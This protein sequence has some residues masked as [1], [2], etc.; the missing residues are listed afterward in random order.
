[1]L[2]YNSNGKV[3][4]FEDLLDPTDTWE[5]GSIIG[6][7]TYGAVFRGFNK[8][9][10]EEVAIKVLDSAHEMI[11][12][13][14]EEYQIL[15]DFSEHPNMPKFYGMY[16]KHASEFDSQVWLVM[17]MCSGGSVTALTRSQL[18]EEEYLQELL[19]AH[20]LK[21]TLTVLKYLHEHNIIHRDVKGHNIL[22]T[23]AGIIKMIDFGVSGHLDSP[24]GRRK[25]HVGTPYWMAPEVIACEQQL[26]YSYDV[27]CDIWSLG[28]TA[29]ELAEGKPPHSDV[30][31]R[32]ALF[33][34]PR[35]P[36]PTLSKGVL[37]SPEFH[38][39]IAKCL[40][41]DF[42]QRS[43]T[44]DLLSHPFIQKVPTDT[45][46]LRK[47]LVELISKMEQRVEPPHVTTKHGQFKSGRKNHKESS[48]TVDD[49]A[50][51]ETLDEDVIIK[52]LSSRYSDE[53][54]YTY[55]GDILLAVNP[56]TPLT[57]YSEELAQRYMHAAKADNPPHI[58][59]VA[60]QAYQS[61][62][63]N[64]HNQCIVIS[65]ESGAG[66]TESAN[67]LV[68]QLTL[69][70]KA[71]NRKLEDR[72]LQVNPLMEAFGN[73]K[74][75]I[76]D[77]S[78]RFGKYLE[79]FFT[80]STGTV[81]GA[82][83]TEYLLEKSRVINQAIGEQ[84]FHIFYYIHDGLVSHDNESE[85]HL[86][87]GKVYRYIY[88]YTSQQQD[89]AAFS[90]NRVRFKA[91]EYCF[92]II[93]FQPD[94]VQSVYRILVAILHTGNIDF[95]ETENTHGGESCTVANNDIVEIVARMLGLDIKDLLECLTTTGMV[96]KGE[97]IVRANSVQEAVIARDAMAKALYGRLFS[98]IVNRIS[99]LLKPTS[100][101][102]ND[103][104]VTGLL[105]IFGFE[106]FE[107]NSFEQLCINIANEQI[108]Y[109]F[110]QHIFA[111]ELAEYE[112]E[113]IEA[114]HVTY[115]D[116]RPILDMFLAKPVGL[117]S[118]LDEESNFPKATDQTL[119]DK[120]NQ[121]IRTGV[122]SQ[123]KGNN[124]L[125]WIEHYAGRVEYDATGFL[126]K[127]RDR[128]PVEI[129]H[130]LRTSENKVVRT[131]FQTPLSKTG[132]LSSGS[133]SLHSSVRSSTLPSP[134][135]TMPAVTSI[136]HRNAAS[137][138]GSRH[139]TGSASMTRI[140]QT[141]A[142]YFRFSLMD[143]LNKMVAGTPHFVR[144]IKP[145]DEKEPGNFDYERVRTQ[146]RYTGVLET[147]RIR[148][149]GFSHRINFS[150]FLKRYHILG[151]HGSSK[152][153]ITRE[154]CRLLLEKLDMTNCAV[155][156]SKVFL[157]YYHV[158]ELARRY[159]ALC[160]KVVLVQSCFRAWLARSKFYKM[161]WQREKAAIT[162]QKWTRGLFAR[163]QYKAKVV[164][165]H[166]AAV[167]IQKAVRGWQARKKYYP[168][169]ARRRVAARTIQGAYRKH[170]VRSSL[171]IRREKKQREKEQQEKEQREK[172]EQKKDLAASHI[173]RMYR[174]RQRTKHMLTA[175]NTRNRAATLIQTYFRMW[176]S[177]VLY[178]QLTGY[179]KQKEGQLENFGQQVENYGKGVIDHLKQTDD[180]K[181][182]A[183][184]TS[185]TARGVT[186]AERSVPVWER[187]SR[188]DVGEAR[189]EQMRKMN[190]RKATMPETEA[191]YYDE[192]N[193]GKSA[194]VANHL[195]AVMLNGGTLSNPDPNNR[196]FQRE[197]DETEFSES[198]RLSR[199]L[200]A[201]SA[202]RALMANKPGQVEVTVTV[203]NDNDNLAV[204]WDAPLVSARNN[205]L[206]PDTYEDGSGYIT[207]C[208]IYSIE[209]DLAAEK[210]GL[211]DEE[212]KHELARR[213]E[214]EVAGGI[215][216]LWRQRLAQPA[217]DEELEI[218]YDSDENISTGLNSPTSTSPRSPPSPTAAPLQFSYNAGR[219]SNSLNIN[220]MVSSN[221]DEEEKNPDL[222][223]AR[224]KL[225]KTRFDYS[226]DT[227][228]HRS[229]K[230]LLQQQAYTS[231]QTLKR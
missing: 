194:V 116:N 142:T 34:I 47:Q 114:V 98:W 48:L 199:L 75:V 30:D 168:E 19:I 54:I 162:V 21:E 67:F 84:N 161:K 18:K 37:W 44:G 175:E 81:M 209:A 171:K 105:D 4:K 151:F 86:Q 62:M 163:I 203:I 178:K 14:E 22:I 204:P 91:I 156:K 17:E 172:E 150:D 31:P 24:L 122:Y 69:L 189:L 95:V 90:V 55:I 16:L 221:Q 101:G 166:E 78:S 223:A 160:R 227:F 93:G 115:T 181:S 7:G 144:C 137:M 120:F 177:K 134:I 92:N 165:R 217:N 129:I 61:M 53:I 224:L 127:N 80:S 65:G 106:N 167:T 138:G 96:A 225:R 59:G 3:V 218:G 210:E 169:V 74:T 72:I 211:L 124:L 50:T 159:D 182:D 121:N 9:S 219:V 99:A 56:F 83:I 79:L 119:V 207:P 164:N 193:Y 103:R 27:R 216:A 187:I 201:K 185:S 230:P 205:T 195:P 41:K 40:V 85:F 148:R 35:S 82:K 20:I 2:M 198:A 147:T 6:E 176:R 76:N 45:T 128:L 118:L 184:M 123:P 97:V 153:P 222:E 183:L 64:Q 32:R 179:K 36:P 202:A 135:S 173:Q 33:K 57:I 88:Q 25:T 143:L 158:E 170:R 180:A 1:M 28:I 110:N 46:E 87:H 60:D 43:F 155:G 157:K 112:K 231:T 102:E 100:G 58:Y 206:A 192:L 15:R 139:L 146:L 188:D 39:F 63:H 109:Y 228:H 23:S 196:D 145:N 152:I 12:E 52:E 68:Q 94:E 113:E 108:Q 213:L 107:T 214:Q 149:Q 5:L 212:D 130:I 190:E 174:L 117:L 8:N 136:A 51:L 141:V 126:E 220:R 10:G 71:E 197:E 132:N 191:K 42:E 140:Q 13:I 133:N 77:N 73:A 131:L 29:I 11:E 208:S 89:V 226:S 200:L 186:S 38:D 125:F 26:D 104:L 229:G 111:W 66:K 215:L 49:L 70:G 154:N